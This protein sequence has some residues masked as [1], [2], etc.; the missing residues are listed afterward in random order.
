MNQKW[1]I[2]YTDDEFV[3]MGLVELARKL[4]TLDNY[5]VNV[6]DS[7]IEIQGDDIVNNIRAYLI[8]S[9]N[10]DNSESL[11]SNTHRR[12]SVARYYDAFK[13][14]TG[15][16]N[17]MIGSPKGRF[18][19]RHDSMGETLNESDFEMNNIPIEHIDNSNLGQKIYTLNPVYLGQPIKGNF[20]TKRIEFYL[21]I[22]EEYID[23]E[24][25]FDTDEP[26]SNCGNF[27]LPNWKYDGTDIEYNQSFTPI[28]TKSG[29]PTSL[30]QSGSQKS[31]YRGRCINCLIGGF[32]YMLM[33]KPFFR[34]GTEYRIFV[35]KGN[36]KTLYEIQKSLS[37]L[38]TGIDDNPNTNQDKIEDVYYK[39]P[40]TN[41]QY[42]TYS[43]NA[44]FLI[45][46]SK[47][48]NNTKSSEGISPRKGGGKIKEIPN[49]N[50]MVVFTTTHSKSGQPVRGNSKFEE[51][52][53]YDSL[54]QYLEP[55]TYFQKYKIDENNEKVQIENEEEYI[56]KS[57]MLHDL[58][59]SLASV[60]NPNN[61]DSDKY[62]RALSQFSEGII[63][64]NTQLLEDGLFQLAKAVITQNAI[65]KTPININGASHY[66]VSCIEHMTTLNEEEVESLT[67][68]GGSIG[69]LFDTRNDI[70]VLIGLKNA[71][72]SE[73][74]LSELEKTGLEAAK[75]GIVRGEN[76]SNH[77]LVWHEDLEQSIKL[78]ANEDTYKIAKNIIMA[79]ASLTALYNNQYTKKGE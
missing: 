41:L 13:Q 18:P 14:Y 16:T 2:N 22:L 63:K 37:V 43:D 33:N 25:E 61:M 59:H 39:A 75:K 28:I 3:N 26:C 79:Q 11:I 69:G 62:P 20:S 78:L 76:V 24:K 55:I 64:E 51:Y 49:L 19:E 48:Y 40:S 77:N 71:H 4:S 60:R 57:Y 54:S 34:K 12:S 36:F 42:T 17:N 52:Y 68:L 44:Q 53:L 30:G 27:E 72:S 56:S 15:D 35:P 58:L 1:N 50:S 23:D 21:D 32:V 8:G 70:S 73:Q 74:F 66:I 45:L 31:N 6:E 29:R 10:G 5:N 7:T 67:K 47:L 46:L 65:V 9:S 38:L